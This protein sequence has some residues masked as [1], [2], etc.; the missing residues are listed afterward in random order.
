MPFTNGPSWGWQG[1]RGSGGVR[2]PK[3]TMGTHVSFI[4]RGYNP[5][6]YWGR[7]TFIFHGFGKPK[8]REWKEFQDPETPLKFKTF[9]GTLKIREKVGYE[10]KLCQKITSDQ[11]KQQT[12]APAS[13][14]WPGLIPQMEV[15]FSAPEKVTKIGPKRGHVEEP[16]VGNSKK[17]RSMYYRRFS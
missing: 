15:T 5:L 6:I 4:S 11:Q 17:N 9:Q 7:K 14:K 10:A 8:G 1:Q 13:S 2:K 3:G 12:S 16:G